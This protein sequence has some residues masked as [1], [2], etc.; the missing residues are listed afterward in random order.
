MFYVL[1]RLWLFALQL[2]RVDVMLHS[3]RG[4]FW[5]LFRP[6]EFSTRLSPSNGARGADP[7]AIYA[8]T[9]RCV[10]G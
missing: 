1:V 7:V 8:P 9:K 10:E 5:L 2:A 4:T 3:A 6:H